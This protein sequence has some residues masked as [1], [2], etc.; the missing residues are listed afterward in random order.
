MAAHGNERKHS[1]LQA[2]VR[3]LERT[4]AIG[5]DHALTLPALIARLGNQFGERAAL[6][7]T[8]SSMSYAGLAAACHRYARWGLARGLGRGDTVCLMM[9]NSPDYLAIWLGL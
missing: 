5:H 1:P 2:W 3:A 6:S 4:A 8:E 7:S 9:A